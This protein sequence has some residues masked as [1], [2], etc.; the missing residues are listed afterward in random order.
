M[1]G[2]DWPPVLQ[3]QSPPRFGLLRRK[4]LRGSILFTKALLLPNAVSRPGCY[5]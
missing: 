4:Y 1:Q 2:Q 3:K 5:D